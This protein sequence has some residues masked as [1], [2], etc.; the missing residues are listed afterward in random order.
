M[1]QK[2]LMIFNRHCLGAKW[3]E[4]LPIIEG[5]ACAFTAITFNETN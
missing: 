1:F 2:K 3:V 5:V 4:N